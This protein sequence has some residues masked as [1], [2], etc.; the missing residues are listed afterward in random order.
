MTQTERD[1]FLNEKCQYCRTEGHIAKICWWIPKKSF[2][3]QEIPHAKTEWITDT[4]ASNHITGQSGMLT[5][6]CKYKGADS[7]I[8]GNGSSI[9]IFG[10]GDTQ[11]KQ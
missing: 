10:I 5:N 9:P 3:N 4:G 6:L 11:I 2:N 8:I 1:N 7:V